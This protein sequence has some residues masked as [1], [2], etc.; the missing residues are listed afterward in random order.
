MEMTLLD[1]RFAGKNYRVGY[2]SLQLYG[3]LLTSDPQS[4]SV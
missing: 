4:P 1:P 3:R 2:V